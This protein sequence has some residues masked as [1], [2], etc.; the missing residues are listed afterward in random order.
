MGVSG[1]S[2]RPDDVP[3]CRQSARCCCCC[4]GLVPRR[5]GPAGTELLLLPLQGHEQ[6]VQM[7]LVVRVVQQCRGRGRGW[8]QVLR[9]RDAG[10]AVA[11]NGR[12]ESARA[13]GTNGEARGTR[14]SRGGGAG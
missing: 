4:C 14:R 1:V 5:T 6:V 13:C 11:H 3:S 10:P 7:L 2:R 12:L 8:H 9:A